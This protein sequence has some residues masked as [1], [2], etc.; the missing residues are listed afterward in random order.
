MATE[1]DPIDE[2]VGWRIKMR[3]STI[4]MTQ[5]ALGEELGLTFQQVQKYEKGANRVS[6]SKLYK[7]A[8]SLKVQ[9]EYFFEEM[10][11][12]G[13][14]S[15]PVPEAVNRQTLLLLASFVRLPRGMRQTILALVREL[16]GREL[17][18]S[19]AAE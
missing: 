11:E 5:Q 1:I 16:E 18:L 2:H 14:T 13:E 9:P 10:D 4:G 6:A 19:P 17:A 15:Q 3:R 8:Q 7:I 12:D